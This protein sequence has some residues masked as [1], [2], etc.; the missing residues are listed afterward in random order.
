MGKGKLEQ[1]S[2]GY[3]LRSHSIIFIFEQLKIS[4]QLDYTQSIVESDERHEKIDKLCLQD[5]D[6]MG[7][8]ST[9]TAKNNITQSMVSFERQNIKQNIMGVQRR[10]QL[11]LIGST[12][13]VLNPSSPD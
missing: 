7:D 9:F 2:T 1:D 13:E 10:K 4:I 8:I 3:P 5:Y 11:I 6:L 12:Q